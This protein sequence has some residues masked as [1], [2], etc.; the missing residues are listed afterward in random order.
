M[1]NVAPTKVTSRAKD[2]DKTAKFVTAIRIVIETFED[3]IGSLHHETRLKAYKNLFRAYRTALTEVWDLARFA[4]VG[5]I[6]QTV[7]D[8]EMREL[9][10]MAR[11]LKVPE[12]KMHTKVENRKVPTLETITGAM[13]S[14]Y[15]SQKLPSTAICEAIGNIFSKLSQV[16]KAYAEA[17][18][19]LAQMSTKVSPEHYTLLLT[20]VTAPAIQLVVPPGITSPVAALLPPPHQATT[21]MGRAAI[22]DATK[23]KVLPDPG[24]PCL[25]E[26]NRNTATWV[27]ATAI[28]SKLERKYFDSTHSRMEVSTAFRCNV[29]Q[30]TKAPTRVEYHSGPHHYKPEPWESCKGTTNQGE[31]SDAPQPKKTR[32]APSKKTSTETQPQQ[33]EHP[34]TFSL[35][36]I[37][38]MDNISPETEDILESESSSDSPLPEGLPTQH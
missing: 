18:D 4:D 14:T 11:R 16:N 13:V 22:I 5:L 12:P 9:A 17:A 21:R 28:Y 29:L 30:L 6:L 1:A 10:A 35:H 34:M 23:L 37:K 15:P 2:P 31:A 38:K 36:N 32:A 27:L 20:A 19:G 8:K 24:A 7:K 25:Q 33:E 26:C 3:E